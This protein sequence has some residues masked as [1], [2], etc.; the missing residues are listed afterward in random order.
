MTPIALGGAHC[1]S[2]WAGKAGDGAL[3]GRGAG[4]ITTRGRPA[5]ASADEGNDTIAAAM[6][7]QR[8]GA[9]RQE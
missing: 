1:N 8:P 9:L 5:S 2:G 3:G 4:T 7:M 6:S